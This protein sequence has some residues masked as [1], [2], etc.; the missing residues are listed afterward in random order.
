MIKARENNQ[1]NFFDFTP[2]GLYVIEK[3]EE[4]RI[5]KFKIFCHEYEFYFIS[6]VAI[7]FT[8]LD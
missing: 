6:G 7:F 4:L 5:R 8:S 2:S 3:F 1:L